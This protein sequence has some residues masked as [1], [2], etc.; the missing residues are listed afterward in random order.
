MACTGQCDVRKHHCLTDSGHMYDVPVTMQAIFVPAVGIMGNDFDRV[1]L[2]CIG[3]LCWGGMSVGFGFAR[4]LKQVSQE[5][6]K[7]LHV[8]LQS[9]TSGNQAHLSITCA[10]PV[11]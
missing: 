11:S 7:S 9:E 3:S 4:D 2:I 6:F 5:A 8:H 10:F 1:I